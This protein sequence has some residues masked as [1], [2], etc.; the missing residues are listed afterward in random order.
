ME[1]FAGVLVGV[2]DAFAMG[3]EE[4]VAFAMGSEEGV[5]FAM[6]SEEGVAFTASNEVLSL[7][8]SFASSSTST[9]CMEVSGVDGS[10]S[11]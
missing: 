8:A 10:L 5:A 3:S 7:S 6:G 4:G 2:T 1:V 9:I 11:K